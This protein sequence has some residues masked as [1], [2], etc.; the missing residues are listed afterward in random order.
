MTRERGRPRCRFTGSRWLVFMLAVALLAPPPALAFPINAPNAR[1]LFGGFSLGSV[2]LRVTEAETLKEGTETIGNPRDQSITTFEEDA[3]F[4]YG[5]TRDLTLGLTFPVIERR[6]RFDDPAGGR[7]TIVADGP[8]DLSVVGVYRVFR[9]DVAD[10]AGYTAL[11]EAMGDMEA[12]KVIARYIELVD[13]VLRPSTRMFERV[14]DE[15]LIV[16]DEAVTTRRTASDLHAAV[17]CEP[18]FPAVRAGVHAGRVLEHD[19]KYFGAALNLT[20]RVASHAVAGQ[21]LCTETVARQAD[22]LEDI[23]CREV[24]PV[25]FRN[26]VEPVRIF[27]VIAS[28]GCGQT[29]VVDPVCR[30]HV[31][32]ETATARFSFSGMTYSFCSLGCARAFAERPHLYAGEA[33][34][35]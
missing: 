12:A 4:V 25:H 32:P 15:V 8:G 18:P 3:T 22:G 29:T 14:G 19:G 24:G 30:M 17:E 16:G 2:R 9:R 1:T 13:R 7:R 27:E 10:L 6:L 23:E 35:R 11:T 28:P 20:A 31:T 34:G 33:G 21:I 5:A 26:I